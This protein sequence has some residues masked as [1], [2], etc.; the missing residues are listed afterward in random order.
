MT[1]YQTRVRSVKIQSDKQYSDLMEMGFQASLTFLH[2][3]NIAIIEYDIMS[4]IH[5]IPNLPH[6]Y[7]IFCLTNI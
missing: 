2:I 3:I 4:N 5:T 6:Q 7:R 1:L